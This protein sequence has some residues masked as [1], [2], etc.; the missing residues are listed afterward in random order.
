MLGRDKD[1]SQILLSDL[2]SIAFQFFQFEFA[3]RSVFHRFFFEDL[4]EV[5]LFTTGEVVK[6][7]KKM[8]KSR[9][10]IGTMEHEKSESL[11]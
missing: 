3:V 10:K 5:N 11:E 2:H 8:E 7:G 6:C 1:V 4:V 9:D